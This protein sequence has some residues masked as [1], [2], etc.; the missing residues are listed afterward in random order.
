MGRS[1][2]RPTNPT[3]PPPRR[4]LLR[5]DL[6]RSPNFKIQ[7]EA[8]RMADPIPKRSQARSQAA[9]RQ[10][11]WDGIRATRE[12][13][14]TLAA[15]GPNRRGMIRSSAKGSNGS[16]ESVMASGYYRK[17]A[18][19]RAYNRGESGSDSVARLSTADPVG[20]FDRPRRG[21]SDGAGLQDLHR[22]L[23]GVLKN[24]TVFGSKMAK[25]GMESGDFRTE[26]ADF[27]M[28]SIRFASQTSIIHPKL[29][30]NSTLHPFYRPFVGVPAC[31]ENH[32]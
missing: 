4:T 25:S 32:E 3:W 6:R 30:A 18:R 23:I 27:P 14:A 17:N 29:S 28:V 20:W 7:N 11:T 31:G 5:P 13:E 8:N 1:K 24:K 2:A 9:Q 19:G 15:R 12:N 22:K 16:A 26:S 21:R 10:G